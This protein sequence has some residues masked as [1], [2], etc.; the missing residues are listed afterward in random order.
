MAEDARIRLLA[1]SGSLRAASVNSALLDA[2][3]MLVPDGATLQRWG[4]LGALPLFNPDL[5]D[6]ACP[7]AA[8]ALRDARP[9]GW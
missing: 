9:T 1:F 6:L 4:G 7:P 3:A 8:Q 2:A 5:E